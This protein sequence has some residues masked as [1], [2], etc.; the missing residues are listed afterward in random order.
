[1]LSLIA[2]QF[3]FGTAWLPWA[4]GARH[5]LPRLGFLFCGADRANKKAPPAFEAPKFTSTALQGS[6]SGKPLSMPVTQP[7]YAVSSNPRGVNLVRRFFDRQ[8][9]AGKIKGKK[10]VSPSCLP[11]NLNYVFHVNI[12]RSSRRIFC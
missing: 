6:T 12:D 10:G 9:G 7:F 11:L 2:G 5:R 1:M 4:P 8:G 3:R